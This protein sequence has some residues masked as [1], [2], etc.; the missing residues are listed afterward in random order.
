MQ[1]SVVQDSFGFS[2][3]CLGQSSQS[4]L[5]LQMGS[6][7]TVYGFNITAATTALATVR[8][9]LQ[10]APEDLGIGNYAGS[11][12]V[13]AN[14]NALVFDRSIQVNL[15]PAASCKKQVHCCKL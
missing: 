8:R 2:P 1:H 7:P 5:V 11:T 3:Y 6:L 9:V 13:D 15:K 10:G 4:L 14:G 12:L